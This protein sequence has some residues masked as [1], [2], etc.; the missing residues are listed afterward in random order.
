M[1]SGL[2]SSFITEKPPTA[3]MRTHEAAP[4]ESPPWLAGSSAEGPLLLKQLCPGY[5]NSAKD[6][7]RLAS[8][9]RFLPSLPGGTVLRSDMEY[10]IRFLEHLVK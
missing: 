2:L 6:F 8:L 3:P 5:I 4:L 7:V 1:E 9:M 10:I